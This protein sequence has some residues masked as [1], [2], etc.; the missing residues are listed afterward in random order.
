MGLADALSSV[1]T[2]TVKTF[3]SDRLVWI[4]TENP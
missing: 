1:M 3:S 2:N 4:A